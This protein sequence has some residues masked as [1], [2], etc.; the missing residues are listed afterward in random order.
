MIWANLSSVNEL[1]CTLAWLYQYKYALFNITARLIN[2]VVFDYLNLS[3]SHESVKCEPGLK[4]FLASCR[5]NERLKE[6]ELE[7]V[8]DH[9]ISRS[10]SLLNDK[11]FFI[12]TKGLELIVI[13]HA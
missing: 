9:K 6:C 5:I 13:L 3:L 12:I 4:E 1:E 8:A 11:D 2:E 10:V 7:Q